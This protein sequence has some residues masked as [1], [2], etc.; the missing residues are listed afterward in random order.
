MDKRKHSSTTLTL[1]PSSTSSSTQEYVE[2]V[3]KVFGTIRYK[4]D[5]KQKSD[6]GKAVLFVL[7]ETYKTVFC[8]LELI[9]SSAEQ[10]KDMISF[11]QWI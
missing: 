5:P 2:E 3:R 10:G 9:N 6:V 8:K 7:D 1:M 4:L 11:L